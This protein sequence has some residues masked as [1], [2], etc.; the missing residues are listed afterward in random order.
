MADTYLARVARRCLRADGVLGLT[1]TGID[2]AL[3]SWTPG[4]HIDVVLPSG[5]CRQYSLCGPVGSADYEIAVLDEPSGRGGSHEV[6]HG[7]PVGAN[8]KISPPR[9][10]FPLIRADAYLFVAGGIGI[11]PLLPMVESVAAAGLPWRLLYCGRSR[12]SMAFLDELDLY[13][14]HIDI[15]ARDEAERADVAAAVASAAA[16]HPGV[17]VYACGP[18]SL[19]GDL[20]AAVKAA[21]SGELHSERFVAAPLGEP[22]DRGPAAAFEVQLGANGPVVP[23]ADDQSILDAVLEAGADVL[24]S[25]EEGTCGSCQSTV[26]LGDVD[27]R[28]DLLTEQER[29]DKQILIC[30]SRCHGDRLVLDIAGPQGMP[31]ETKSR[32]RFA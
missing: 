7:V 25:C 24:Y 20:E 12:S 15:V 6:H 2:G 9:N 22:V 21:G 17:A 8:L 4:A 3:P 30:V 14:E 10:R 28:D 18:A 13:D 16:A 19:L 29:A 31:N 1:L 11:T 27:H 23:V 26:L 32:G 5:L